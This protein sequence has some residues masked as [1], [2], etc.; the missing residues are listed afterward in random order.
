MNVVKTAKKRRILVT[1]ANGYIG[2]GVIKALK[3]YS[4][5]I[6]AVDLKFDEVIS[7]IE[8]LEGNIFDQNFVSSLGQ[9]DTL[10]HLAWRDGFQHFSEAHILDVP[11][12]FCFIKQL[13]ESG[14]DQVCCLGSMH[15]IGFYEGCI[16]ENTP[17]NP[18]SYY[19]IGKNALRQ[20]VSLLTE[21]NRA[22]FQWIRGFYIVGNTHKGCSVF[23][24]ITEAEIKG[25]NLFPFTTGMNQFDFIDYDIF[26]R[27]VAATVMQQRVNG[28]INCCSGCPERLKD[29]VERFIK[30]NG[31]G[32]KLEY[33]RFLDRPYDSKAVWGSTKKI[34]EIMRNSNG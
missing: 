21:E 10:L 13:L 1:G 30:E 6:V 33:G 3:E 5:D 15:E 4:V 8:Q 27:Q 34:D 11:N 17:T 31:Y 18:I 19:G 26:C 16:D 2:Q 22:V 23:S 9:V 14:V 12:H 29:R 7:G 32:I 24:K 20:L 25:E 28:I